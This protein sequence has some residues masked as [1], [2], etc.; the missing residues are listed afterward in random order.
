[1]A[2][3]SNT[4]FLNFVL[5]HEQRWPV[6]VDLPGLEPTESRAIALGTGWVAVRDGRWLEVVVGDQAFPIEFSRKSDERQARRDLKDQ[7]GRSLY[8]IEIQRGAGFDEGPAD[9][10]L[11][12]M[13]TML[14]E[15]LEAG[16]TIVIDEGLL[17]KIG[18]FATAQERLECAKNN[19]VLVFESVMHMV[20]ATPMFGSVESSGSD[21]TRIYVYLANRKRLACRVAGERGAEYLVTEEIE[22]RPT[23]IPDARLIEV[24]TPPLFV[25]SDQNMRLVD[26]AVFRP[27]VHPFLD[28]WV[29]YEEIAKNADLRC[30]EE[31]SAAPL[32][33]LEIVGEPQGEL[34]RVVLA[35]P[36]EKIERWIPEQVGALGSG[37][38]VKGVVTIASLGGG[39]RGE[40]ELAGEVLAFADDENTGRTVATVRVKGGKALFARGRLS[41]AEDRGDAR[42]RKRREEA[43]VAMRTGAAACR[44]LLQYV[45]DPSTVPAVVPPKAE[46][47]ARK[48]GPKLNAAQ[49]SAVQRAV[50]QPGLFLVQGPPGTG[51]TSVIV[52]L[53]HALRRR[54]RNRRDDEGGPL[55]VLVT[56]V[57]NEAV[58]NAI[59]KLSGDEVEVYS[60]FGSEQIERNKDNRIRQ[61]RRFL[62]DATRIITR[63]KKRLED[64]GRFLSFMRASDLGDRIQRL[65]FE[66]AARRLDESITAEVVGIATSEEGR[67]LPALLIQKLR[68][69]DVLLKRAI[70]ADATH[71]HHAEAVASSEPSTVIA[72]W[73]ERLA[74]LPVMADVDV[75][76]SVVAAS[77]SLGDQSALLAAPADHQTLAKEWR[78]L[79]VSLGLAAATNTFSE[80]LLDRWR[81]LATRSGAV[82]RKPATV[83]EKRVSPDHWARL[84][85]D[86]ADWLVLA[87]EHSDR[88]LE[89]LSKGEAA[90]V[91]AWIRALRDEPRRLEKV[92]ARHAP[93]STAT[94]Q[95]A[96]N[97]R[98]GVNDAYDVVIIDEAARAGIDILIPMTLGRSVILIGDQKQLPPHVEKRLEEQ[99]R[100]DRE[101]DLKRESFFEWLWTRVPGEN[102]VTLDTQYRM[103]EVIGRV[104][105]D[106]F[107][108]GGLESYWTQE[109][110]RESE[111]L[112]KFGIPAITGPRSIPSGD[113]LAEA[114]DHP[115]VWI[116]TSDV[117]ADAAQRALRRLQHYP[118]YELN[119]Y[120]ASII[121]VLL[122]SLDAEELQ[123]LAGSEGR[124]AVGVIAFYKDQADVIRERVI[125]MR[126]PDIE[127]H[128]EIGTVDSFQGKEYPLVILSAVRS[129]PDASLGFLVLP[130][131]INVAMS[132]AQRQLIIVGDATTVAA[133][134]RG[135]R[136]SAPL[137]RVYE[138]M[139]GGG[140]HRGI[141][142]QSRTVMP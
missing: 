63:L 46:Y 64:D 104:V 84:E 39:E 81:D 94:C 13:R 103:H 25:S 83:Q 137:R 45:C 44:Q 109:R 110:S 82:K 98:V 80:G 26:L 97:P 8:R 114:T 123:R 122:K 5:G 4:A 42:Q 19:A 37:V 99:M 72:E 117:L 120:E 134:P 141:I 3:K 93:V 113:A 111:R 140:C 119:P 89:E 27:R 40:D 52:E 61:T 48:N 95:R 36:Q 20:V 53:I 78:T 138:T 66:M 108:D 86:V 1:M 77:K 76:R 73:L 126:R 125:Q 85:R 15:R 17:P 6:R 67:E 43:I 88:V 60:D 41:A 50:Q 107:Y 128:L 69:I 79:G 31:R 34:W 129:N 139:A 57:Q 9:G 38:R 30:Y 115:L 62:A 29:E 23:N 51:K 121:E 130:H 21:A 49:K 106:V 54:Y 105:S 22:D 2:K 133:K 101:V 74:A 14:P 116:D 135:T 12:F 18:N 10:V 68:D 24:P 118:C 102:R 112:P 132:R 55:R 33:Y 65:R 59:E 90:V 11:S 70:Q 92:F 32:E 71:R 75:A 16:P 47:E 7:S 87:E 58:H 56:S 131:R 124:K 96:A 142:V 91:Y 136:E 28:A 127:R 35:S 100:E